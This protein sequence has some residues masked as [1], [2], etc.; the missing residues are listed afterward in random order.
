MRRREKGARNSY[1]RGAEVVEPEREGAETFERAYRMLR[2][3]RVL[4]RRGADYVTLPRGRELISY[5]ANGIAHLCGEYE[6]R[7]ALPVDRLVGL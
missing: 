6:A 1:A 5:Y 7:D 2:M 3:R 4:V